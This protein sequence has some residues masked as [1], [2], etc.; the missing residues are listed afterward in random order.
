MFGWSGTILEIDLGSGKIDR[1]PLDIDFARQWLG[2]EGFG[3]KVLWDEVGP[4]VKDG[5]DPRNVLIY[6]SG[7]LNSTLAPSSGRLEIVTRSPLTGIFGDS[8]SGGHFAPEMKQAGYD[9]IVIKGRSSHPVYLWIDDDEVQI[10]DAGHLWGKSVPETSSLIR[11]ENKDQNIQVS[12]IGPAGENLVRFA[13]LMN[14]NVRAAGWTGSGAV[15]GSKNLKAVA[16]RGTKGIRIARPGEF[17]QACWEAREK[18]KQHPLYKTL[19]RIGTMYLTRQFYLGGYVPLRNY[20]VTGCSTEEFEQVS[21][22]TFADDYAVQALGCHGCVVQCGHY[23][24]VSQGDYRG[25]A[26]DGLEF[27]ALGAFTYWYGSTN[28]AFAIAAAKFCNENGLDVT[29]PA[30]L[31]AWATDCFKRGLI[32]TT[33]TDGLELDW[34]DE[35]VAFE[36]M[37]KIT[38]REGVGD[39]F[40]EGLAR[41]AR[42]IGRGTEYY[43]QTIKGRPSLEAGVRATMGTAMASITSTRGADHLKGWPHFEYAALPPEKSMRTWGHPKTGDGRSP[44]GKAP[45][46]AYGQSIYTIVDSVGACKFHSRIALNGLREEDFARLLSAATGLDISAR[47]V[48]QAADRIY[49][50]E[51]AYNCLLGLGRKDDTL[52]EMY[53]REPFNAGP[54]KGQQIIRRE[55]QEKMLD[56]YYQYRGWDVETGIPTRKKLEELGLADVADELEKRPFPA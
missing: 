36:I 25:T 9:M 49:T 1:R 12:C 13:A 43:A 35:K 16:I 3:A 55:D 31:L 42:K 41:A 26:T 46:T 7:P 17:E 32:T 39:T 51:R 50:L 28:L 37:R 27:S 24:V 2:G 6:A 29:E 33:D 40:A 21:G 38:R 19:R 47:E 54:W 8:N 10:R 56:E 4:E 30:M 22:D 53:F 45:M 20:S 48:M 14:N 23:A 11:D 52:P 5:L 34:G 44:E 18:V 15:A